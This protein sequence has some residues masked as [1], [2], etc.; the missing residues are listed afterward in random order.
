M[1]QL[2]LKGWDAP[3]AGGPQERESKGSN[4]AWALPPDGDAFFVEPTSDGYDS[5]L[6]G[7]LETLE[8]QINRL[9]I[10][11]LMEQNLSNASGRARH[12]DRIDSDSIHG[13]DASFSRSC[14]TQWIL[15]GATRTSNL[16]R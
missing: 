10:S 12:M 5:Q 3:P 1:P 13:P 16:R 15:Q 6:C 2:C 7:C 9:G 11:T 4:F 14:R 8:A